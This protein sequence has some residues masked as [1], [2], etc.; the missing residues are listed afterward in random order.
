MSTGNLIRLSATVLAR[1]NSLNTVSPVTATAA[2]VTVHKR[3]GQFVYLF[4]NS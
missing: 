3:N 1:L 4:L 2:A